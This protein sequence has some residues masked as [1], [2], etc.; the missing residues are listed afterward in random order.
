MRHV[1]R[2][3]KLPS[4][5]CFHAPSAEPKRKLP[6]AFGMMLMPAAVP[7]A[8]LGRY[9]FHDANGRMFEAQCIVAIARFGTAGTALDSASVIG[10]DL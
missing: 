7:N 6:T 3:L 2:V 1:E 5:L 8:V 9:G 10:F 4:L